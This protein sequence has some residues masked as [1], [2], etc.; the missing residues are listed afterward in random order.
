L[1]LRAQGDQRQMDLFQ[2]GG[3]DSQTT[4][5]G[6]A[7]QLSSSWRCSARFGNSCGS[8]EA[9]CQVESDPCDR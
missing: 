1:G 5:T 7:F 8:A 6:C 4:S 9:F 2:Q 3:F